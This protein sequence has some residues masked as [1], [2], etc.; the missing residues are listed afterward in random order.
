MCVARISIGLLI[1][2]TLCDAVMVLW[3]SQSSLQSVIAIVSITTATFVALNMSSFV[4]G[5]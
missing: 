4:R 5:D 3:R 2:L 1:C